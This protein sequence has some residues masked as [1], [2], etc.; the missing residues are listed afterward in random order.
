MVASSC[1]CSQIL[2]GTPPHLVHAHARRT[3][4]Q[5]FAVDQPVRLRVGLPT[6]V[7]G[8]NFSGIPVSQN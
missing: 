1:A 7:V 6:T 5:H 2:L 4:H 3:F 8:N